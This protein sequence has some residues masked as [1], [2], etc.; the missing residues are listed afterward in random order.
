MMR[1][2]AAWCLNTVFIKRE[3]EDWITATL[4]IVWKT[5]SWSEADSF[6]CFR[7]SSQIILLILQGIQGY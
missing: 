3:Y 5:A 1:L 7:K 6:I 4:K 2:A